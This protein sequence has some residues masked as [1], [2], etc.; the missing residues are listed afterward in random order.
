MPGDTECSGR[1]GYSAQLIRI[2]ADIR[3]GGVVVAEGADGISNCCDL[4]AVGSDRRGAARRWRLPALC[5]G[6]GSLERCV[7]VGDITHAELCDS[8]VSLLL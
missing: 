8:E 6:T 7:T 3:S 1:E 2:R 5:E 4:F